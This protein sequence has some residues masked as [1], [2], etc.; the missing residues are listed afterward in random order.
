MRLSRLWNGIR[1]AGT[2]VLTIR[3][4]KILKLMKFLDTWC[5]KK[6]TARVSLSHSLSFTLSLSLIHSLSHTHPDSPFTT[7]SPSLS[8][9]LSYSL[10]LSLSHTHTHTGIR[11]ISLRWV[12]PVISCLCD[13]QSTDY[14][15][16]VLGRVR[17]QV[18][19]SFNLS[20]GKYL[21][22]FVNNNWETMM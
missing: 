13:Y 5:V 1:A 20:C 2:Y 21:H 18:V 14:T 17:T 8:L 19:R 16:T 4:L 22:S 12:S 11:W 9:S 6:C 15:Q 7:L 3:L 10:S